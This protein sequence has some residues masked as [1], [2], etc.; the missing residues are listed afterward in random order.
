V[1]QQL[2]VFGKARHHEGEHEQSDDLLDR[3]KDQLNAGRGPMLNL[4]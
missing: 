2:L 1:A 3:T 4:E